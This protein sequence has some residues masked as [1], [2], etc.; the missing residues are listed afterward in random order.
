MTI[1]LR[2]TAA[3]A[4]LATVAAAGGSLPLLAACGSGG[5]DSPTST[6][7]PATAT[8]SS[9]PTAPTTTVPGTPAARGGTA[10]SGPPITVIPGNIP[11][12]E[13]P[14]PIR[15]VGT[16][17]P[18]VTL[19]DNGGTLYLASGQLLLLNL[20]EAWN[21]QV[22]VDNPDVLSRAGDMAAPAGSQGYYRANGPGQ[23][24]LTAAG[25]PRCRPQCGMPS[26]LFR[27]TVVV[28]GAD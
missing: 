7:P 3:L 10:L 19:A 27:L 20:G 1:R 23:A 22:S 2:V 28:V 11:P 16:G 9:S 4:A 15:A 13:S 12:A 26:V 25:D 24:A 18:E 5:A 8:V 17:T 14:T 6:V 21:W